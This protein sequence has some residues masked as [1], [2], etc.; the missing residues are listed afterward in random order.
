MIDMVNNPAASSQGN[1]QPCYPVFGRGEDGTAVQINVG[2]CCSYAKIVDE[3]FVLMMIK[4]WAHFVEMIFQCCWDPW[5][6]RHHHGL[7]LYL[8]D[9]SSVFLC[10]VWWCLVGASCHTA[11]CLLF[12]CFASPSRTDSML[13]D[14]SQVTDWLVHFVQFG[15]MYLFFASFVGSLPQCR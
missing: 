1:V 14:P 4:L 8:L 7:S 13:D 12:V 9:F 6:S 2:D 15:L 11:W 10:S 3:L 5:W